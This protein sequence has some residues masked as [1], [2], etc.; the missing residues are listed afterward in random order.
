M[1]AHEW[2]CLFFDR[3]DMEDSMPEFAVPVPDQD[4]LYRDRFE[5]R[6]RTELAQLITPEL[7]DEHRRQP[8]GQ[9]SDDLARVLRY[10]RSR[11]AQNKP[12][13]FEIEPDRAFK[14]VALS[15]RRDLPPSDVDDRVFT[16]RAA[17]IHALFELRI[18]EAFELDVDDNG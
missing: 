11:P 4:R 14:I 3:R 18:R 7:I 10:L 15:G 2:I 17:A 16:A 1:V 9:H 12:V 13:L 5:A 6:L 8:V